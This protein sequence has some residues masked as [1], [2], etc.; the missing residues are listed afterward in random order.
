MCTTEQDLIRRTWMNDLTMKLDRPSHPTDSDRNH[1]VN[2]HEQRR[3]DQEHP[4]AR[5]AP[6][7]GASMRFFLGT[8]SRGERLSTE[9]RREMAR[10]GAVTVHIHAWTTVLL[11]AHNLI[12]Y[13]QVAV[14]TASAS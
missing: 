13:I 2:T 9:L 14:Y 5:R 8:R 3:G 12:Q 4:H 1:A 6:V 10:Y 7:Y 11:A